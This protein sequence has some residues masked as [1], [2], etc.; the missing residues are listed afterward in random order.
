VFNSSNEPVNGGSITVRCGSSTKVATIESNGHYGVSFTQSQC[1]SG[2]SAS[3]TASTSDGSGTNST[4]VQNTNVNGPVVDLDVAVIDITVPEFG[5]I[6]G[7][8]T[9]LGA[10]GSYL[11]MRARGIV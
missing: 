5:M 8:V 7:A 10:V 2:D 4:T 9:A 11:V 6:G 3:A 1:K